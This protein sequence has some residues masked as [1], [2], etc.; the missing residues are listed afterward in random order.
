MQN[1]AVEAPRARVPALPSAALL[2]L[3]FLLGLAWAMDFLVDDAFISFRY[4]RHLADGHG[5]V[6]NI[7]ETPPV[8]SSLHTE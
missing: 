8:D 3:P 2:A 4:G 6:W 7:G 5:L 1:P